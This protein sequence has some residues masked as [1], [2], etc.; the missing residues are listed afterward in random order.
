VITIFG[1]RSVLSPI[2]QKNF[3]KYAPILPWLKF[4]H[5]HPWKT[6]HYDNIF[7]PPRNVLSPNYGSELY[8]FVQISQQIAMHYFEPMLS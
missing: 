4:K 8:D 1:G 2:M 6:I 7:G 5:G 3:Q